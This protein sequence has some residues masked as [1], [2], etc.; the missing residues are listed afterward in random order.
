MISFMKVSSFFHSVPVGDGINALYNSLLMDIVFST[1]EELAHV[2]QCNVSDENQISKLQDAGIYV[3]NSSVDNMALDAIRKNCISKNSEIDIMYLIVSSMCNFGCKYCFVKSQT[4]EFEL[5]DATTAEVAINKF[6]KYLKETG[7]QSGE[8]IFYGGEPLINFEVIR[9]VVNKIKEDDLKIKCSIVTNGSL[10][11]KEK[12]A[13]FAEH[14]IDVGISLDGFK[15]VN[16]KNRVYRSSEKGTYDDVLDAVRLL[17]ECDAP[18]GLSITVSE[19]LL[20]HQDE[21]ILWL[22]TLDIKRI[23]YNLLHFTEKFDGWKDY[24]KS[25]ALFLIKSYEVLSKQSIIDGRLFRKI[26]CLL[27]Q[28]FKYAD[29]AAIGENQITVQPNGDICICHGYFKKPQYSISNIKDIELTSFSLS[30]DDEMD[31]WRY[32]APIFNEQCIQCEALFLCGGGCALQAE[33]LFGDR[34][35]IDEPFC[36]HT[37]SALKWL[38]EKLYEFDRKE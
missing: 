21:I 19:E 18:F 22:G 16:D 9:R 37:K 26:D 33:A 15:E 12:A 38:L 10:I 28:E 14:E 24:Y 11:D 36:I 32:R 25:A 31:F 35:H 20:L 17:Q 5:M 8:V 6:A 4:T 3:A 27:R 23:F 34:S 1:D 13:F 29:C 7:K 30:S 2:I